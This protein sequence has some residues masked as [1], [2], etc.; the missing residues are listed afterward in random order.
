MLLGLH[1]V[2]CEFSI[3]LKLI[4]IYRALLSAKHGDGI[5]ETFALKPLIH[6]CLE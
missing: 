5:L 1:L 4:G 6:L 3:D 2:L